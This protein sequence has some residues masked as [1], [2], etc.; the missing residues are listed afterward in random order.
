[1]KLFL[2]SLSLVLIFAGG[3]LAFSASKIQSPQLTG[4]WLIEF[5]LGSNQHRLQFDAEPSGEGS[6][7]LLDIRSSL[8]D[9]ATS[10]EAV[11]NFKGQSASVYFFD[12]SGDIEFPIGNAGREVGRLYFSASSDLTMPIMF[13][14]GSGQYHSLI[15]NRNQVTNFNF[16]AKRVEGLTA[17]LISPSSG[18]R[19]IR[20][21]NVKIEWKVQ[22]LAP[23]AAQKLF[24]SVD[25]GETF[26]V[27]TTSLDSNTRSF[28]WKIPKTL[29]RT[30]KALIKVVVTDINSISSEA[31][32]EQ[33]LR[34]K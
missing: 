12:V 3:I 24:L 2:T 32:N 14:H 26:I 34:I 18:G 30:R 19:L 7:L 20:G 1:M 17:Q 11:W 33:P 13:L 21:K 28:M 23:I 31:I 9:P 25:G 6:F 10:T 27:I 22:S 8:V 29:P 15:T 4:R 5:T 16:T